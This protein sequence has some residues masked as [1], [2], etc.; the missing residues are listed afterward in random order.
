MRIAA[1]RTLACATTARRIGA[2]GAASG[3]R[4]DRARRGFA[5]AT[6]A[7]R[8]RDK[9]AHV[10]RCN[11]Q[12]ISRRTSRC[13]AELL[14]IPATRALP[15]LAALSAQRR[16]ELA[17][18][19]LDQ[20]SSPGLSRPPVAMILEDAHWIDPTTRELF[21]PSSNAFASFQSC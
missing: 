6:T 20:H 14:S 15:A 16:K 3:R 5:D 21:D 18:R 4:A 9:L 2:D 1:S 10:L 7:T 13:F 11:R 12:A 8:K 19:A 17:A